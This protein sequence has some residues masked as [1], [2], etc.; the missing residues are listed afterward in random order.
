[1]KSLLHYMEGI[2]KEAKAEFGFNHFDE[3]EFGPA[4]TF[5]IDPSRQ[6]NLSTM[7]SKKVFSIP[8][9]IKS[10]DDMAAG[11]DQIVASDESDTVV[12]LSEEGRLDI[13]LGI[14]IALCDVVLEQREKLLRN[15]RENQIIAR[16]TE[17]DICIC[18]FQGQPWPLKYLEGRSFDPKKER[19]SGQFI[20]SLD[21]NT[22][23]PGILYFQ[24]LDSRN[25]IMNLF[26]VLKVEEI[27]ELVKGK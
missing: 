17:E 24:E 4:V 1:M 19:R 11:I 25:R 16:M 5:K 27:Q 18:Y 22:E 10:A 15:D 2:Q 20:N 23:P 26:H 21:F 7:K 3:T 8:L 12:K 9:G 13:S 14:R 6:L